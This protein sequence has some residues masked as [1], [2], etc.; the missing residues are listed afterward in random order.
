M[1]ATHDRIWCLLWENTACTWL[2]GLTP[3]IT[4]KSNPRLKKICEKSTR[5]TQERASA[6]RVETPAASRRRRKP[7]QGHYPAG[8]QHAGICQPKTSFW[9]FGKQFGVTAF[10]AP[11]YGTFRPKNREKPHAGCFCPLIFVVNANVKATVRNWKQ[12]L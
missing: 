4:Q 6:A 12:K 1:P 3:K 7:E 11:H 2:W 10:P 8:I 9:K 5:A